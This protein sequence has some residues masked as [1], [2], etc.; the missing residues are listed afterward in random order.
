MRFIFNMARREIRSSWKR[1]LFFFI[2]IGVGVGA[3][4]ALRSVIQS[5]NRAVAGEARQ[6]MSADV[7]AESTRPFSPEAL[8]A[9]ERIARP[10][11]VEAR[12]ETIEAST[13]ARPASAENEGALMVELKGVEPPFPFYGEFKLEGAEQFTHALLA[14]NGAIVAPLLLERLGLRTGD[15]IKI[16][17]STFQIRAVLRQEPGLGGG[18]RL[19]PRVYVS[20]QS[21]EE[22]GLTGFGSRARRRLLFKTREGRMDELVASLRDALGS[23]LVTVRSYRESQDNLTEQYARAENYL[24]LTGLVVLV[25][26]GI[27]VSS[28]TRV[29]IEQKKKT[30]AVLKCVG[31]TGRT[32][33]AA[34]LAQVLALGVAGSLLGVALAKAALLFVRA[35]FAESLPPNLSYDLQP[36]AVAQGFGLGLLISLLFS[37]LPLLRIRHIKPNMLLREAEADAPGKRIDLWRAVVAGLVLAG[38]LLL[39]S[40]QA[41]SLRVGL[42]FLG[43]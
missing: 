9:I 27:G 28:V 2:C 23:N 40:W 5:V 15:E 18:F 16:G 43:G 30:I 24:A 25:L 32:I 13:M 19:G 3:I 8:A 7:Q 4:V 36:G 35:R 31:G 37:A 11:L 12:T 38:L 21:L 1:L 22:A 29:F 42:F 14:D 6:L 39:T 33:T 41:G 20:R 26:G 17:N 10:P 34:Y